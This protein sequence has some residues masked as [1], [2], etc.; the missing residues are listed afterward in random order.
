MTSQ[1]NQSANGEYLPMAIDTD[2]FKIKFPLHFH[3][4]YSLN[5]LDT[6]AESS[7]STG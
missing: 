3:L 4:N 2:A 1:I 6:M 7:E 5:I